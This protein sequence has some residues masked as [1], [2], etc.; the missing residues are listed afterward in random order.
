ML[1]LLEAVMPEIV[2]LDDAETLA[3]LHG[4]VSTERQP[5]A[6]PPVPF[7]IDGLVADMPLF[8][9][10]EPMLGRAHLRTLT[11][12]GFPDQT[13]PGLLDELNR[14]DLAYRWVARWLPLDKP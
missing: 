6:V 9:G 7:F 5:V 11:L 4:C 2:W 3:Y 8:P 12:R 14:L 13:W 10:I 1:G